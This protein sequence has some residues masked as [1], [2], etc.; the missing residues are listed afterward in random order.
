MFDRFPQDIV[1]GINDGPKIKRN[2]YNSIFYN[3]EKNI[4]KKFNNNKPDVNIFLKVDCDTAISRKPDHDL[5]ILIEKA[6]V[7]E[8]I[9]NNYGKEFITIDATLPLDEVLLQVKN[10][11]WKIFSSQK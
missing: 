8:N 1:R 3:I 11:L 6:D 2:K 10:N 4:Y 7:L 9:V 5:S